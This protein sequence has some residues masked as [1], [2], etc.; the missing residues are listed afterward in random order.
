MCRTQEL[1][2]KLSKIA[3]RIN[4]QHYPS[5]AAG[6]GRLKALVVLDRSR[7]KPPQL[8]IS[9]TLAERRMGV[10]HLIPPAR[11]LHVRLRQFA[12]CRYRCCCYTFAPQTG[13]GSTTSINASNDVVSSIVRFYADHLEVPTPSSRRRLTGLQGVKQ[14]SDQLVSDEGGVWSGR[15]RRRSLL[16]DLGS[17]EVRGCSLYIP[18]ET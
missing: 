4:A 10:Q 18:A 11:S 6:G 1:V 5:G 7:C 16:E 13:T 2:V 3:R 15:R 12:S 17:L 8:I 14:Q 9:I